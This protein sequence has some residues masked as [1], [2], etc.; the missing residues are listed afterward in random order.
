MTKLSLRV[1]LWWAFEL[2]QIPMLGCVK[3]SFVLFYRRLFCTANGSKAM[4]IATI[5]VVVLTVMWILAAWLALLFVCGTRFSAW[6]TS[7][8]QDKLYCPNTLEYQMGMGISDTIMDI[9]IFILPIAPASPQTSALLYL[10]FNPTDEKRSTN[11]TCRRNVSWQQ[12]PF[13]AWA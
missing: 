5:T 4:N 8:E 2:L 6:W 11:S 13:S 10:C 9:I 12:L 3:L 1:Q 7:V